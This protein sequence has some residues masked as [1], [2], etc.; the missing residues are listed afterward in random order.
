MDVGGEKSKTEASYAL[1]TISNHDSYEILLGMVR[2]SFLLLLITI[3]LFCLEITFL[4]I[5]TSNPEFNLYVNAYEF[6]N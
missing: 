4:S 2:V 5:H 1:S 3:M 6:H